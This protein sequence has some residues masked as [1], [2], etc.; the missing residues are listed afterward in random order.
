MS[1]F[2]IH[3][4]IKQEEQPHKDYYDYSGYHVGVFK[5]KCNKCGKIRNI[6][7]TCTKVPYA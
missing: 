3:E 1:I 4:W 5:C 7:Y 6:K 2:C